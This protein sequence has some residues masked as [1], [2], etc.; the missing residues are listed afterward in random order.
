MSIKLEGFFYVI[1]SLLVNMLLCV[2]KPICGLYA[3]KM[4]IKHDN[5]HS[6]IQ[7][8]ITATIS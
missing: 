1:L 7:S 3:L 5:F 4:Q 2:L 8:Q 6:K